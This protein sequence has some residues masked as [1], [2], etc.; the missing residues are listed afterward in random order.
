MYATDAVFQHAGNHK[1]LCIRQVIHIPMVDDED[2]VDTASV[3]DAKPLG[4]L[5]VTAPW[6][7]CVAAPFLPSLP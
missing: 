7:D 2:L 6:Q 4:V 5:R 1:T 3:R